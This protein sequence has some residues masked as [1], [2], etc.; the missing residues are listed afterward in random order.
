LDGG[1]WLVKHASLDIF[2]FSGNRARR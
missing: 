1:G 2:G